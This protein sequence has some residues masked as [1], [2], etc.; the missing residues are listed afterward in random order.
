[1]NP[2]VVGLLRGDKEDLDPKE[3]RAVEETFSGRDII[4]KRMDSRDYLKHDQLC[5]EIGTRLV[6]LPKDRPIPS[7]AMERGV[8]HVIVS[9]DGKLMELLPLRPEFKQYE[10]PSDL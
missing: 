9:P 5:A 2:V 4:W 3:V 8:A 10:P 6:L 1:M 7:K